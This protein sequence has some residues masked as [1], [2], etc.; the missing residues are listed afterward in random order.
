MFL[1]RRKNGMLAD[2]MGCGKTNQAIC[3]IDLLSLSNEPVDRVLIVCPAICRPQW[4]AQ[5]ATWL[6]IH[7][8]HPVQH[9][10]KTTDKITGKTVIISYNLVNFMDVLWQLLDSHWDV[11]IFDEFHYMKNVDAKR[12]GHILGKGG[13]ITKSNHNWFLSGTPVT[14]PSDLFAVLMTIA[15][16]KLHPFTTW[17]NFIKQFCNAYKDDFGHWKHHG[18][19][20]EEDL[21]KRL[22]SVMLRRKACDVEP[23]L[24]EPII[25]PVV[26][27]LSDRDQDEY[28]RRVSEIDSNEYGS[29]QERSILA[30][31]K[32]EIIYEHIKLILSSEQKLVVFYHHKAIRK[33]LYSRVHFE[34]EPQMNVWMIDGSIPVDKRPKIIER[35]V[36]DSRCVLFAQSDAAGT[37]VDGIQ[38]GASAC[39]FAEM[40]WSPDTRD[41][42]IRR[43]LRPG[44]KNKVKAIMPRIKNTVDDRILVNVYRKEK[45]I[46]KLLNEK[47][48]KN[49]VRK[50]YD[51]DSD[52]D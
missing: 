31:L 10:E 8:Q 27:E 25:I 15:R 13:V 22:A 6:I 43:L 52:V 49:H 17:L 42:N 50:T 30:E 26:L 3:A 47:G 1:S 4:E 38:H 23:D 9:I 41:Q 7:D 14:R 39:Y 18:S 34:I 24:G 28:D 2:E 45:T 21:S 19:C 12:T 11:I 20:N 51:F 36:N 16:S 33:Y 29:T 40:P 44:Q 35:F 5:L 32:G 46:G 37:G 48:S